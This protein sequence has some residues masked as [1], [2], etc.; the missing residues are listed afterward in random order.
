MSSYRK[1]MTTRVLIIMA[2]AVFLFTAD[3]ARLFYLQIVKGEYYSDKAASQQLS[4]TEIEANRG[5]IYDSEG[6]ILAQ[7]ATVWTV[8][9]DPSNI[10]DKNRTNIV[11]FLA[12]TFEYDEE[13]KA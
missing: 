1:Q 13:K 8:F 5:T 7:S 6:N 2:I 10:T 11:D 3:A 9:L 12:S 4:D